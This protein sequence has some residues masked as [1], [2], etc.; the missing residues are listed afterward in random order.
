MSNL[1]L[2]RIE[3]LFHRAADLGPEERRTL[4][5]SECAGDAALQAAVEALLK[6]DGESDTHLLSSP[7]QRRGDAA[8]TI[9]PVVADRLLP[10]G[11]LPQGIPGYEVLEELG[12]G[13]MGV[14]YKARQT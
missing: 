8:I 3:E 7:V 2:K 11:E 13:G 9:P 5:L 12:R 14:V 6:H 10:P 1:P 4:L